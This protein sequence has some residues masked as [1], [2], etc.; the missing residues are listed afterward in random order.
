MVAA[1]LAHNTVEVWG[2]C[3]AHPAEWQQTAK[4]ASAEHCI[5]YSARIRTEVDGGL[6]CVSGTVFG[7][8]LVWRVA[9]EQVAAG[10]EQVAADMPVSQRCRGHDGVLFGVDTLGARLCS[11][12]DD[13]SMRIWHMSEPADPAETVVTTAAMTA[14]GHVARVRRTLCLPHGYVSAGEDG[15]V[16]FWDLEGTLL[17][18]WLA[19]PGRGVWSLACDTTAS[20]LVTGGYDGSVR[21]FDIRPAALAAVSTRN[22]STVLPATWLLPATERV[23]PAAEGVLLPAEGVGHIRSIGALDAA[24]ALVVTQNGLVAMVDTQ[25]GEF[26][27]L[28]CDPRLRGYAVVGTAPGL[29]L[30]ALG[31]CVCWNGCL[32]FFSLNL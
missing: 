24:C 2:H 19:H 12:S 17:R 6:L 14:H 3:A 32:L 10:A 30:A 13:R 28:F 16:C 25:T 29:A 11:V 23:S 15:V 18:R 8:V 20:V 26:S 31:S 9:A 1:I 4:F 21:R 22:T 7:D 27:S 5:L